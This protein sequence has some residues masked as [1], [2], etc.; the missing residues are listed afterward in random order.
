[1][2]EIKFVKWS[3]LQSYKCAQ[4][5]KVS[6]VA[7]FCYNDCVDAANNVVSPRVQLIQNVRKCTVEHMHPAK[8]QISMRIRTI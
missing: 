1:M 8:I 5:S 7:F 3:E 6:T 4:Y 2:T